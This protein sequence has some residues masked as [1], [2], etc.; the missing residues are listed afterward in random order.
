[1]PN[2]MNKPAVLATQVAPPARRTFYPEP[3]A[4]MV[5]GR[6]KRKLGDVFGLTQ[7]GVNL[8]SIE[9]GAVSSMRH[10][11]S[12]EDEF[13]YVLSGELTLVTQAGTQTVGPGMCAG[14]VAGVPDAHQLK[15]NSG[16]VAWYIEV[17][18]RA[19]VDGVEYPDVDLAYAEID[20]KPGY[21]RK[22]GT[23]Y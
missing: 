20:G 8:C 17:G 22:D 1:M 12:G 4:S 14:F 19:A 3:F 11:H 2:L 9:P 16:A 7:F 23:P 10:W 13:I 6:T 21:R 15:N 18:T 5:Q